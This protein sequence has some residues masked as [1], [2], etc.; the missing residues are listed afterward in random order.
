MP[1][2]DTIIESSDPECSESEL[3]DSPVFH[4]NPIATSLTVLADGRYVGV[5]DA[6]L[7]LFGYTRAEVIGKTSLTLKIWVEPE[8]RA[9]LIGQLHATGAVRDLEHRAR[10]RDGRPLDVLVSAQ[11]IDFDGTRYNLSVVQ[12][13]TERN[14]AALVLQERVAFERLITQ[15]STYF[16]NLDPQFTD[17]GICE[18]LKTIGEFTGSDRS[19][20]FLFERN[21]RRMDNTHEWCREGIES[22]QS[23]YR[24]VPV[25]TLPYA[26]ARIKQGQTVH[27]PSLDALPPEGQ[28]DR[29]HCLAHE[30]P[31]RSFLNVPMTYR[32]KVVGLLGFDSVRAEKR[33]SDDSM[34]LLRI[35]GDL[36]VNALE[37][38]NAEQALRRSEA[39]FRTV[40]ENA[41]IGMAITDADDATVKSN[42]ALAHILGYTREELDRLRTPDYTHPEDYPVQQALEAEVMQGKRDNYQIEKR[43]IRK[44][45]S[46]VWGR[47][48]R[49]VARDE[50]GNIL[51]RIG[52]LEDITEQRR[53][54][55][56]VE[57]AYRT[58]EQ[59]VA[60]R[61]QELAT[62]N[63][64]AALVSGSLDLREIM[65]AALD[66]VMQVVGMEHGIAYRLEGDENPCLRV[67]A[68][69][70]F[71]EELADFGDGIPV[72][73]SAAGV[74]SR[75]GEPVIWSIADLPTQLALKQKLA[76]VGVE[77]V[78]SIP[79]MAKGRF[80]GALNLSTNR[81]RAFPPEQIALL[82]TIGQQIGVA[83][84]NARLYAQA[85]QAAQLAERSR[86]AR[87]LHD[88]VTQSL[89]SVSLY[90]EAAV[91]LLNAG[92]APK[93]QQHLQD[94]RKTAQEALREMRLLIFELRPPALEQNSLVA[95][96]HARLDAVESRG[97][98]HANLRIQGKEALPLA[99]QSE[100]YHIA[101]ES[102]NNAL[103]HARAQNVDVGLQFEP[104]SVRLEITDDGVGF[105][106]ALAASSGGFG[107]AGIRE[108]AQRMGGTLQIM[109]APGKGTTVKVEIPIKETEEMGLRRQL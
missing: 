95:A 33:W 98:I 31:T 108:R 43:Y 36:F 107:I 42:P 6:W 7:D 24:N 19:Y 48:I 63:A 22:L 29:E 88:S 66:K 106:L 46:V 38:K 32:G 18:A 90:A 73:S 53:A 83:V 75:R 26:T 20:V 4:A 103:K 12:D 74:A 100:L 69:Q 23:I 91:R 50:Q 57:E 101:M 21:S 17:D 39:R 97:G 68:S 56:A 58:M 15:I 92:Q 52:M 54:A 51:Y 10:T 105:E 35:V 94:V 45:G 89:Y 62:L 27:I 72:R 79:L 41:G 93:A 2:D 77:Q 109:S 40:F 5:N 44:D 99:I 14:R 55:Q 96:L 104:H 85:E 25:D 16:I 49:S 47:M 82:K 80:V 28:T 86:L 13:I 59:R 9:I 8:E 67:I 37:Q 78:I 1:T 71:P 65:C 84:E 76:A 87:E 30:A 60:D 81:V 102:L 34:A 11:V 70:G 64:I 3:L 61:T